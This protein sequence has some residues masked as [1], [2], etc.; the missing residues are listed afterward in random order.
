M[1]V[2][3]MTKGKK[4]LSNIFSCKANL[5]GIQELKNI[6]A[7]V[8]LDGMQVPSKVTP[9]TLLFIHLAGL[10]DTKHNNAVSCLRINLTRGKYRTRMLAHVWPLGPHHASLGYVSRVDHENFCKKYSH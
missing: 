10:R 1:I 5:C 2:M 6:Q 7:T 9:A 4:Y 3:V 8:S